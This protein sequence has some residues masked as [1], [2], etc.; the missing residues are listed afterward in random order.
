MVTVVV[1]LVYQVATDAD[2]ANMESLL[3]Q[4]DKVGLLQASGCVVIR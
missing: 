3:L 1:A 4:K 2:L